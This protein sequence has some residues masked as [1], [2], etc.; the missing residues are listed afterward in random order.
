MSKR[1]EII[2]ISKQLIYSKGYQAT[3]ISDILTT[4]NIGKGQFYH[5]FS[6]KHDLGL[7]VV[8]DLVQK[9]DQKIII[10]IFHS[11]IEPEEKLNIMLDRTIAFHT[12]NKSGCPMGN[13]AIEMS[14]HDEAFRLK[15]K[16]YFDRFIK[17]IELCLDEMIKRGQLDSTTNSEKSAQAMVAL[18]EG[19]IL[20]AKNQQD[21]NFLKNVIDII[22]EQYKLT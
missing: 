17:A 3:A 2:S 15:I 11:S 19:G 21:I 8:E 13:L 22:R 10:D 4:A 20:L 12:D 1:S 5:Y 18:I 16:H 9:W 7:A 6:S 14:E